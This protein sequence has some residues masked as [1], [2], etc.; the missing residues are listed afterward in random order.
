[1]PTF[2]QITGTLVR[3]KPA[4]N[5]TRYYVEAWDADD[6]GADDGLATA[7]ATIVESEDRGPFS[8]VFS[9]DRMGTE[10]SEH[11][12]HPEVYFKLYTSAGPNA[13][14]PFANTRDD[15]FVMSGGQSGTLDAGS[16]LIEYE[17]RVVEAPSHADESI[18][19]GER[20]QEWIDTE[21]TVEEKRPFVIDDLPDSGDLADA[22]LPNEDQDGEG[23]STL[24]DAIRDGALRVD[25]VSSEPDLPEAFLWDYIKSRGAAVEFP[26]YQR[27]LDHVLCSDPAEAD[28]DCLNARAA[29][30][31]ANLLRCGLHSTDAYDVLKG[32]TEAFLLQ[33]CGHAEGLRFTHG[34]LSKLADGEIRARANEFYGGVQSTL[35]AR[36]LPYFETI[37]QALGTAVVDDRGHLHLGA[38]CT[39]ILRS[40]V[41]NPCFLELIWNYWHEQGLLVQT[42]GAISLRF[43]N[44]RLPGRAD[45]PLAQLQIDPL[46]P[47]SNL[48]WGYVQSERDQLSVARRAYEYL[49]AYGLT[50]EGR[51]VPQ[52]APAETR[53]EFLSAFH[54]L[55][56]LASRFY[57]EDNDSTVRADAFPVLNSLRDL[58]MVLA[59]GAHNQYGDLPWTARSEMLVQQYLLARPEMREFLGGRAMVPYAEGWMDRVETVK[60]LVGWPGPSVTHFRDLAVYGEQLLLSVRFGN[61]SVIN[62]QE[63]ARA[64]ALAWRSEIQRY[65]YAYR[66]VT[67]V[68]LSGDV[69]SARLGGDEV[70]QPATLMRRLH[71]HGAARPTAPA[72]G[73]GAA[74]TVPPP[75]GR[76]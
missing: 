75:P 61:W 27:Y 6:D 5:N 26:V 63:T 21:G 71:Q 32:A 9:S 42:L 30:P 58:H 57:A 53:A 29:A 48:L 19:A 51:A 39:G 45:D 15:A 65:V 52:M 17:T 69:V 62:D 7:A 44:R 64:W 14:S 66:A 74:T 54:G 60:G 25:L 4:D 76:S 8:I 10:P 28:G 34:P 56:Q 3:S 38:A 18:G 67:G 41:A 70:A 40:R 16:F 72:T 59:K 73:D 36:V 50:I 43:Q 11:S 37:Q 20:R 12:A 46:R 33:Q 23:A 1:M 2:Y 24:S 55:L 68:D 49:Y 31:R 22:V 47:L 13:T 35:G